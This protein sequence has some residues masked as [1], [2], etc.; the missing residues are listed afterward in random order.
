M[1][2]AKRPVKKVNNHI[3]KKRAINREEIIKKRIE[4][5]LSVGFIGLIVGIVIGIL[6]PIGGIKKTE[7]KQLENRNNQL[8]VSLDKANKD[9]DLLEQQL[10]EGKVFISLEKEQK[11]QVIN[12]INA[13]N[14]EE[15]SSDKTITT[16]DLYNKIYKEYAYSLG[17][18]N[19]DDFNVV[20]DSFGYSYDI[21]EENSSKQI[22]LKNEYE[23]D[24]VILTFDKSTDNEALVLKSIRYNKDNKYIEVNNSLN[25]EIQ[26]IIYDG[27]V[28]NVKNIKEQAEFLFSE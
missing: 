9:L 6:I 12:Y 10:E 8:K 7:Y 24:N 18:L 23:D 1:E 16:T 28:S 21:V 5:L 25:N 20:I 15:I 2:R 27:S 14:N 13:L 3:T 4:M 26:Y 11:Q 17:Y 19:I 22:T